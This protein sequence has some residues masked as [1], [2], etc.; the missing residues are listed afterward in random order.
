MGNLLSCGL[1]FPPPQHVVK[2]IHSNGLVE[3]FH[4][5]V[6]ARELTVDYPHH[7]IYSSQDLLRSSFGRGHGDGGE[8]PR[9]IADGFLPCSLSDEE[10]MEIGQIYFLLPKKTFDH[11]KRSPALDLAAIAAIASNA[12]KTASHRRRSGLHHASMKQL[13]PLPQ[14]PNA[15]PPSP[16]A[17]PSNQAADNEEEEEG[18]GGGGGGGEGEREDEE[19]N[20]QQQPA[21][22]TASK[23]SPYPPPDLPHADANGDDAGA[24]EKVRFTKEFVQKLLAETKL[25]LRSAPKG[26]AVAMDPSI[27]ALFNSADLSS[28]RTSATNASKGTD[29]EAAMSHGDAGKIS[30]EMQSAY[31]RHILDRS[32]ARLWRPPL[33]TIAEDHQILFLS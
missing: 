33:D 23:D 5:P 31:T 14:L 20:A 19:K 11:G 3:E 12:K 13:A 17:D 10:E 9:R 27:K 15:S 30:A 32:F 26:G 25:K 6:K 2:L 4:R 8:N 7:F 21:K 29:A 28:S 24:D 22:Q 18:G 16:G 1:G